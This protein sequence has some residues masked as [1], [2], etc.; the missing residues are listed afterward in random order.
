MTAGRSAP[1]R[2]IITADIGGTH[3]RLALFS[4]SGD[5]LML[6]RS[7]W[8]ATASLRGS[9]HLPEVMARELGIDPGGVAAAVIALA[10]PVRGN[11]GSLSNGALSL[12]LDACGHA[13]PPVRRLINDFLAQAWACLTEAGGRARLLLPPHTDSGPR[14]SRPVP[15]APLAVIGAGTG[16]GQAALLPVR[17]AAC[18]VPEADSAT[19]HAW[20]AMPSEGGHAAFPFVGEEENAFHAFLCRRFGVPWARGDDVLTGRGLALLHE[21]LSGEALPPERA[22]AALASD[23]PTLRW[24]ARFY[25]RAC[26]DWMLTTLCGGLWIAGGMAA[27]NPACVSCAAFFD[28]LYSAHRHADILRAVPVR[29]MEDQESGLWGA[30][31]CARM[32]LEQCHPGRL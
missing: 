5:R 21:F 17:P 29:L 12:D 15:G 25:G 24:Y 14:V 30:A 13:L 20:I 7:A 1:A 19:P 9:A 27:R 10:G 32:L 4:L 3:C 26:R 22:A 8:T 2:T 11:A 28:E 31:A 6:E 16:L 18:A 23:T